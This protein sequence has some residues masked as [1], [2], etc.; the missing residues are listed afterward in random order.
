[1][2]LNMFQRNIK[3]IIFLTLKNIKFKINTKH[4]SAAGSAFTI[5]TSSASSFS[6]E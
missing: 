1:M 2:K 5:Q 3:C 6:P 4:T